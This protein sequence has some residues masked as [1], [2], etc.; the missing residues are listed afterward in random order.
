LRIRACR[1]VS[2]RPP[3]ITAS[4]SANSRHVRQFVLLSR[5]QVVL[6][7]LHGPLLRSIAG[8]MQKPPAPITSAERHERPSHGLTRQQAQG[9]AVG[10]ASD[11]LRSSH[12][13]K[14]PSAF[15]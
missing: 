15:R 7:D 2:D 4:N 14:D 1:F 9:C 6:T 12:D 13:F 8:L 10:A 5:G 11:P 3:V